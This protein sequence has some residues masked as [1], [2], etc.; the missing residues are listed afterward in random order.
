[1][2]EMRQMSKKTIAIQVYAMREDAKKDFAGT[3]KRLAGMGYDGVELAGLYERTPE[4]IRNIL[5]DAGLKAVGAH[6]PYEEFKKDLAGTVAAYRTIGCEYVAIPWLPVEE[7]SDE[8][9]KEELLSYIPVIAAACREQG[10][11]LLYHNHAHEFQTDENG[12]YYL[13]HLFGETKPE[14]LGVELDTGWAQVAGVN[15][16][17]YLMKYQG[18]CP[19]VHIKDFI[20]T[21]EVEQVAVGDGELKI[22]EIAEAA[23]TCKI[24][25]FIVEQDE[26]PH[27]APMENAKKSVD[28]LKKITE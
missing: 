9:R 7:I 2:E 22:K 6:V 12:V 14:D 11:R 27:G 18:R 10:M 13:D 5:D 8:K 20:R 28:Y 4:E 24:T 1:M 3:M 19:L 15:P 16:A 23:D 26:Y 17:E 21:E 25:C